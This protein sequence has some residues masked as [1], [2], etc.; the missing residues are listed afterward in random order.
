[1]GY[2][3]SDT[4]DFEKLRLAFAEITS[5]FG[6]VDA[7]MEAFGLSDMPTAQRYGILFGCL[8]FVCT[9]S[10][11]VTLLIMGGSFQR[12]KQQAETGETTV[13]APHD[14]RSQR[15][16]LMETLL[17]ARER[18]MQNCKPE[19]RM[20]GPTKLMVMLA[21]VAPENRK[22]SAKELLHH[23]TKDKKEYYIP[24]MYEANYCKAYRTCQDKPGGEYYLVDANV[25]RVVG[26]LHL[27][28]SGSC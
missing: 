26:L 10:A 5:K 8:V 22:S 7:L 12:I 21:N 19:Q 1:M 9:V 23:A 17:D 16:L 4:D 28:V 3:N 27:Q 14:A 18:M 20:E 13:V 24:P 2:S 6:S 25:R 15:P 11:V